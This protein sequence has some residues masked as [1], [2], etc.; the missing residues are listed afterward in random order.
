LRTLKS[1]YQT[2]KNW[3]GGLFAVVPTCALSTSS[4]ARL[5]NF[6]FTVTSQYYYDYAN[7]YSYTVPETYTLTGE[8]IGLQ[9]N[10]TTAPAMFSSLIPPFPMVAVSLGLTKTRIP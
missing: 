4:R 9:N 3:F 2:S 1:S 10:A 7:Y 8:I 5:L 6:D